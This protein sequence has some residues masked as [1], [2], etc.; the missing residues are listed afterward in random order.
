MSANII[1]GGVALVADI[2]AFCI[3]FWAINKLFSRTHWYGF[4][5]EAVGGLMMSALYWNYL[6]ENMFEG[7]ETNLLWA[8]AHLLK[9]VGTSLV[10]ISYVRTIKKK[11][12]LQNA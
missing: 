11:K 1:L 12:R 6:V 10:A 4:F 2:V 3:C 7:V 5:F 9:N 8:T